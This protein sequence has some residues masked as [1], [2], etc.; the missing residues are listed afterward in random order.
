VVLI[1]AMLSLLIAFFA[2]FVGLV[3]FAEHVIR[4]RSEAA[5]HPAGDWSKG[6]ASQ[7]ARPSRIQPSRLPQLGEDGRRSPGVRTYCIEITK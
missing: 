4:P 1:V 7:D 2:L 5:L 6:T 3:R